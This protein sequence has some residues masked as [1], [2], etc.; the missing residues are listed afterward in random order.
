MHAYAHTRHVRFT[1]IA[2]AIALI[3]VMATPGVTVAKQ[4]WPTGYEQTAKL[5]ASDGATDDLNG[6]S[7][8]IDGETAVT[9]APYHDAIAADAGAAYAYIK[10]ATGW[11]LDTPLSGST[12][13]FDDRFG[14]SVAISGDRIIVGA[15][16]DDD[17]GTDTGAAYIFVRTA[18]GWAE[19]AKLLPVG[20]IDFGRAGAAV[21][22][23]GDTAIFSGGRRLFVFTLTAEGWEQQDVLLSPYA[24]AYDSFGTSIAIDG[25]TII[26]GAH[27]FQSYYDEGRAHIFTRSAGVWTHEATLAASDGISNDQFGFAVDVDGDTALVGAWG[28]DDAALASGAAYVFVRS[29]G[30]WT[31]TYKLTAEEPGSYDYYGYFVS[32]SEQVAAVGSHGDDD[33]AIEAGATH[34]YDSANGFAFLEKL[35]T[36]DGTEGDLFGN[37]DVSGETVI[38][39]AIGSDALAPDAGAAYVFERAVGK[40]GNAQG[41]K[42][43]AAMTAGVQ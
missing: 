9:G 15:P 5:L 35:T 11:T 4:V 36:A 30:I 34:L 37:C 6:Y 27:G 14:Q 19:E 17:L 41:P 28:C 42:K 23:D 43:A 29:T 26:A 16:R 38:A 3:G 31:E 25:D 32:L 10:D 22:I 21:D 20:G 2:I 40:P 12:I 7:V 1:A 18:E 33:L 13:G 8:G 39:G 24:P